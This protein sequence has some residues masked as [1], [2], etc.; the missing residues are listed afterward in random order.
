MIFQGAGP[1]QHVAAIG[2][3][4]PCGSPQPGGQAG[5]LE[6]IP[7]SVNPLRGGKRCDQ[8]RDRL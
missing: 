6:A 8:D 5:H 2:K 7:A 3:A 1:R 4:N